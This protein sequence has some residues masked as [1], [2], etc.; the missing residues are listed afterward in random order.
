MRVRKH[1]IGCIAIQI[2]GKFG[3]LGNA[4]LPVEKSFFSVQ[5]KCQPG[6]SSSFGCMDYKSRVFL[7]G[8]CVKIGNEQKTLGVWPGTHFNGRNDRPQDISEVRNVCTLY[9]C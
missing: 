2:P 9:A 4:A 7:R 3:Y 5:S 6:C 8:K 1:W